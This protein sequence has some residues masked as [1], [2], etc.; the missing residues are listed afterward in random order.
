MKY[1]LLFIVL[2]CLSTVAVEA[3]EMKV[4]GQVTETGSG[5]LPGVNVLVKG[6]TQGTVT[7]IDGNYTISVSSDATLVFSFIG[8]VTEEIQVGSQTTINVEMVP[9]VQ[10]LSEVIVVGYGT[11]RKVDVT[12]SISSLGA[13]DIESKPLPS[14]ESALTGKAAGVQ[15]IQGS[16]I[17]GSAI[18]VR[19]RG[20][21]SISG[22]PE[23]LYVLDGVP[24][25][26][27][28]LSRSGGKQIASNTN[29]LASLNPNDIESIQVLKD[30]AAAAI[31]GSRASNGV[32]LITTK[33]GTSGKGKVDIGYY[34]GFNEETVRQDLLNSSEYV[35]LYQEAWENDGN[36]GPAPLPGGIS[37]EEALATDTDWQDEVLR[38]GFI[39]NFNASYSKGTD[40]YGLYANGTYKEDNSFLEGNTFKLLSGR[41]NF[42]YNVTEDLKVSIGLNQVYSTNDRVPVGFAGGLGRAQG[43][44]LP[45]YPI[46]EADGTLWDEVP[47]TNPLLDLRNDYRTTEHRTFANASVSY[48]LGQFVPGLSFKTDFGIDY[49]DQNEDQFRPGQGAAL[50]NGDSR[51]VFVKN[52]TTNNTL[53]YNRI[54][55]TDHNFTFLLGQSYNYSRTDTKGFNVNNLEGK[56]DGRTKDEFDPS[57]VTDFGRDLQEFSFLSYFARVNYKFRDKYLFAATMRADASSRF[58]ENNLWGYFPSVSAGWIISEEDFLANNEILSFLKLRTAYGVTGNAEI[59]NY[60]EYGLF[61]TNANYNNNQNLIRGIAPQRL[62]NPDLQWEETTTFD[63]G[64]EYGLFGDRIYGTLGYYIKNA[65]NLVF[66]ANVPSSSGFTNV[67]QNALEV[68]VK[69][70]EVSLTSR[71]LVGDF[72]WTTDLNFTT[73]DNTV[74]DLSGLP[75]QAF[76]SG[77][78]GEIR[79]FEGEDFATFYLQ[80][81]VGPDPNNGRAIYLDINGNQ[82]YTPDQVNDA[83]RAGSP[84][85]DFFGGFTNTFSYKNFD[86]SVLFNFSV[87]FQIYNGEGPQQL[88]QIAGFNQRREILDR[89][90][91]DNRDAKYPALSLNTP[92]INSDLYLQDGDFLRLKNLQL[93]YTLPSDFLQK[94]KLSRARVFVQATNLLLFTEYDQGDPEVV[95]DN[96][97]PLDRSL[98]ASATYFTPPQARTITAGINVSF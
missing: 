49:L 43:S 20:S 34:A 94:Y 13:S 74:K 82:T 28:D 64:L 84:F 41:V 51:D 48:D 79:L 75:P 42:D 68:E 21:T 90:T 12:G 45:I 78:G 23:P 10:Q 18:S 5:G 2:F 72:K 46:R 66:N 87:G 31:Y 97:N 24:I 1:S 7:D 11:Q 57:S 6:S 65:D 15:V 33:R 37:R 71:N 86:L 38:K 36:V 17:A 54:L 56:I 58:G 35:Q 88:A 19:V 40:K 4:S 89:W 67:L 60:E 61:I 53:T 39:Q 81:Y 91:P 85:P 83:V 98:R 70:F 32:V 73:I 95:R 69:G 26:S 96:Q 55:N 63:I 50:G 27:G 62:D 25:T 92:F 16:G 76:D 9:D 3:Q 29:A 47:F 30:A 8:Y 22:S 14:F 80:R 93:G 77:D 59:G 52:Y 44:A